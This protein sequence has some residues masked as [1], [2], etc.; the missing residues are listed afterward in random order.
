MLY[1]FEGSLGFEATGVMQVFC[2]N[3][4]DLEELREQEAGVGKS[5]AAF[6]QNWQW[7]TTVSHFNGPIHF[8]ATSL[9]RKTLELN[10]DFQGLRSALEMIS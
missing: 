3:N 9:G 2:F 10:R 5:K 8:F 6:E 4:S 7:K 1:A